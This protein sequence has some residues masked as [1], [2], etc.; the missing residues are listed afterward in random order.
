[1][2]GGHTPGNHGQF[3]TARYAFLFAPGTYTADVPVGFYTTIHGL[4][5]TPESVVFSGDKGVFCEEGDYE[6]DVGALDTFWRGAENFRHN[7]TAQWMGNTGMLWAVSQAA[8]LRRVIVDGDLSLYEYE[9]P[10]QGA[11]YSSGGF[12]GNSEVKGRV[13]A[14]SQQQWF[15]RN[16]A[17][18]KW[19][20]GVWNMV[21]VG[22]TG[23]VLPS[24]CNATWTPSPYPGSVT[25]IPSTPTIAEKP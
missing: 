24:G 7:G 12:L 16:S 6:F 18:G 1:M 20:G 3:S 19:V 22:C 23:G 25:N 11:G 14:G 8:P 21:F 9:P 2:N 13:F 17:V 4:G 15:S 10:Y 5:E